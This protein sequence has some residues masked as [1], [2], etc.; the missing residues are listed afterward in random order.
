MHVYCIRMQALLHM[1]TNSIHFIQQMGRT[2]TLVEHQ[3]CVF[4]LRAQIERIPL[5]EKRI[6]KYVFVTPHDG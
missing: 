2:C 4:T 5:A 3:V 6:R 1:Y